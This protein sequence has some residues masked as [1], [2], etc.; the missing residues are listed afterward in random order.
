MHAN[1]YFIFLLSI[2][3]LLAK[4]QM[5]QMKDRKSTR[6]N[7][8]HSQISYAVFCLKKKKYHSRKVYVNPNTLN[9]RAERRDA[10]VS[11][12]RTR[13]PI[14]GTA[15]MVGSSDSRGLARRYDSVSHA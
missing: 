13:P 12:M 7:S 6:L 3:D 14:R 1:Q 10:P 2:I 8:S 4:C 5:T 9:G 11:P 15:Q